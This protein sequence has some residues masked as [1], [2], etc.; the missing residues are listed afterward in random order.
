MGQGTVVSLEANRSKLRWLRMQ[1]QWAEIRNVRWQ[2]MGKAPPTSTYFLAT[3]VSARL[4]LGRDRLVD[5]CRVGCTVRAAQLNAVR[6]ASR[7]RLPHSSQL[8]CHV[9][10]QYLNIF[11]NLSNPGFVLLAFTRRRP[12]GR[13]YT[14]VYT[15]HGVGVEDPWVRHRSESL[16]EHCDKQALAALWICGGE[17]G[18][19]SIPVY[20]R[21]VKGSFEKRTDNILLPWGKCGSSTVAKFHV[22][23]GPT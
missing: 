6:F 12:G 1:Q 8:L 4:F 7:E 3:C 23:V 17:G 5:R 16:L 21:T 18:R 2:W 20:N 15:T 19:C 22:T 14:Q 9:L 13:D 11:E 10:Q